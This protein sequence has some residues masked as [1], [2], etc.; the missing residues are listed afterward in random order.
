MKS[1][2]SLCGPTDIPVHTP[3]Q[4][5]SEI[6][7]TLKTTDHMEFD[8]SVSLTTDRVL[9]ITSELGPEEFA[10][11]VLRQSRLMS[12]PATS[13]AAVSSPTTR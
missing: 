8:N 7:T 4:A 13:A 6:Q 11:K 10:A 2:K 12:S 5:L 9:N 1:R 3:E